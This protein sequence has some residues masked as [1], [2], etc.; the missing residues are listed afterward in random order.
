MMAVG[1]PLAYYG[2]RIGPA[3]LDINHIELILPRLD[4]E[5]DGFRLLHISDIHMDQVWMDRQRLQSLVER[6]LEYE[7]DV[8]AMTGD[9][10]TESAERSADDL[11]A[12]F[13]QLS[14]RR[15]TVAVLG[16]HDHWTN[17]RLVHEVLRE[18]NV[19]VLTNDV[20]TL[21][22]DSALLHI[23]GVDDVME[24][25]HRIDHVLQKLP[26]EGCAILLAHE[27]DYA[28]ESS[29]FNRFDLQLSGHSHGGQVVLPVLGAPVLPPLGVKYPAG[30]YQIDTMQLYTNRGLGMVSPRVRFNCSPEITIVSL[31][32]AKA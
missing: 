31:R 8:I 14:A 30:L 4:A 28:D 5:F 6:V 21:E 32:P 9:Y 11:V 27:P 13:S 19:I 20:L 16:N 22:R 29:G 25:Q 3:D 15:T 2:T 24:N 1:S 26:G 7:V 18:S 23:G 12:M 17:P 10:V